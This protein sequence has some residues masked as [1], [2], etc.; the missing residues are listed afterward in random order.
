MFESGIE[1]D[2]FSPD[3]SGIILLSSLGT[4]KVSKPW[5]EALIKFED[6]RARYIPGSAGCLRLAKTKG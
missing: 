4:L 2:I 3:R 5:G 6:F 1:A